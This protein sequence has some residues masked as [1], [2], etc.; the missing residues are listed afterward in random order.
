MQFERCTG[1]I[2]RM[3]DQ[4]PSDLAIRY[5]RPDDARD[6][7]RLAAL[8]FR[9]AYEAQLAGPELDRYIADH[10]SLAQQAAELADDRLTYLVVERAGAMIGF[11]LLRTDEHHPAITGARPVMLSQI[12]LD[13]AHIGG[14]IGSTL[15]RRCLAEAAERGHDT[16]WLGVWEQNRRAI[17]FYERWEFRTVG[18]MLFDFAGQSQRD[19]VM[20]RDVVDQRM[21]R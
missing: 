11:A 21:S 20:Q 2:A 3:L 19:L 18:E 6:L 8:T 4:Q 10:Y 16:M 14:G 12:Y 5:G 15:M 9:A 7:S 13:P 1:T 17:G